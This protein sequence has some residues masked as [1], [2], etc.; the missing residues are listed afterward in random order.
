MSQ[1]Q[2]QEQYK[3]PLQ[4]GES[5]DLSFVIPVMNEEATL[6][7]LVEGIDANVPEGKSY[8]VIFIDDGSTDNSWTVIQALADLYPGVVVGIR[9][10]ANCGKAAGLQTGFDSARGQIVFTM[11]ADLQDDP[12]E[13]PR[14]LQ[15][16]DEGFDLVSG[17]KQVRHDPWHK[18]LPS[19][20][21]NRMLSYFSGVKLHDHNCGFKCYRREV[22]K[23]VQLFG[24]L[25]RMVPSL[26]GIHGFRVTE[27]SVTHHARQHG[28][29]KYGIERFIRGFSDM[30]TVGFLRNYRER[31]AHFANTAATVYAAAAL[32]PFVCSVIIGLTTATG[33]LCLMT[34]LMFIGMGGTCIV[35][36][37][38]SELMIRQKH[39]A[40]SPVLTEVRQE[41]SSASEGA[42]KE[43][44]KA[45]RSAGQLEAEAVA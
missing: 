18:V 41:V 42:N 39:R 13:I 43:Q 20:A 21:F 3:S 28:V 32:I 19:R 2:V 37:L 22:V 29:S 24:E 10:R 45:S 1:D 23:S 25:H 16:L 4:S 14:F 30:L 7:E 15:K 6:Q 8:E 9:F 35:A 11:D 40:L 27:I 26:A 36:G 31:P 17:W 33:V 12:N 44:A 5:P 34:S 38:L